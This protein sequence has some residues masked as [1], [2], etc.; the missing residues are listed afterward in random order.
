M[1][2]AA[3]LFGA[4][5]FAA[6][7]GAALGKPAPF[8]DTVPTLPLRELPASHPSFLERRVSDEELEKEARACVKLSVQIVQNIARGVTEER[9]L[10]GYHRYIAGRADLSDQELLDVITF[11]T[12]TRAS[13]QRRWS[14][15]ATVQD[16]VEAGAYACMAARSR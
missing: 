12:M 9:Y 14:L 5:L 16:L 15:G 10:D 11:Q 8:A 3:A 13:Y 6:L 1:N 2:I 4:C 7:S